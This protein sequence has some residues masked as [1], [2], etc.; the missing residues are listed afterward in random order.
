M[1]WSHGDWGWG[2]WVTMTVVMVA[3]W[4]LVFWL[5]ASLARGAGPGP[6]AGRNAD[7][8]RLLAE[9]FAAG[10]IAAEEFQQRL[11]TLRRARTRGGTSAGHTR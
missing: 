4:G 2:A 7:P 1:W 8:E 5:I 6:D 9:R 10:E 11:E 3:F